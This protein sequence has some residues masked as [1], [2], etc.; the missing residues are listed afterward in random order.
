MG[1]IAILLS[2]ISDKPNYTETENRWVIKNYYREFREE[3]IGGLYEFHVGGAFCHD[4]PS[5]RRRTSSSTLCLRIS[6]PANAIDSVRGRQISVFE[7]S[8]DYSMYLASIVTNQGNIIAVNRLSFRLLIGT[9]ALVA[10]VLVNSY[11]STVISYMTVSKNKPAINTFEDLVAS[12]NVE[13]I[14]LADTTTKK[15]IMEA[16]SGAMKTLGDQIRNNPSRI[17]NNLQKHN[18]ESIVS[19]SIVLQQLHRQSISGEGQVPF[20]NNRPTVDEH[21]SV[22]AFAK[23]QQV[24]ADFQTRSVATV[25][26]RTSSALGEKQYAASAEMLSENQPT[27]YRDP[28]THSVG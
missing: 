17:L 25:G 2:L 19:A 26:D 18:S 9:W 23:K 27:K 22:R 20:Q 8:I 10:T 21:I 15:Q 4:C 13:L 11:S 6:I 7:R 1:D 14:V 16:E 12:E 24:H 5:T 3:K 28:Q